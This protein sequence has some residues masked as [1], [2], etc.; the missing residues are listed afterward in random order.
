[1]RD[2]PDDATRQGRHNDDQ[3]DAGKKPNKSNNSGTDE[4]CPVV[5]PDEG[6]DDTERPFVF[7]HG[8]YGSGNQ[9]ANLAMLFGSNG[10]CQDRFYTIE[11]NS[12][13]PGEDPTLRL[14]A[15]ID[16]V[17]KETGAD[18]VELAGHSQG[19]R[20]CA[21]YMSDPQRAAKVAHYINFSGLTVAPPEIPEL[22]LS[23]ENDLGGAP[24]LPSGPN[25][26]QFTMVEEDHVAVAGS[27]NAFEATWKFLYG[28]DPKYKVVQCG[29]EMITIDGVAETFGDNAPVVNGRLEIYELDYN[30]P[31]RE[32]GEPVKV[33]HGDEEGRSEPIQLKRNTPYEFKG[34][35][36]NGN[37]VGYVYPSPFRRSNRIMRY[38][39]P[40]N[41]AFVAL[42][43]TDNIKRRSKHV[44]MI[45]LNAIGAFR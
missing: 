20:H 16:Q 28:K 13:P 21:T 8:T 39:V 7:V 22:A 3:A 14:D 37:L 17:L 26:T 2:Q 30:G 36:G 40:S 38:F 19:T 35:D 12:V 32:R 31:P 45:G 1:M 10:Y 9:I 11:Y 6:C 29:E 43:S 24:L 27:A 23:S 25:I 4:L 44:A 41:N 18:K 42:V 34:F 5:V 15:L 33:I